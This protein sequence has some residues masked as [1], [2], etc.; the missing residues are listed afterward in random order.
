M[1][2]TYRSFL[3]DKIS[4]NIEEYKK[5]RWKSIRQAL[6]VSYSQAN[7]RFPSRRTS[8]K[9]RSVKRSRTTSKPKTTS[10]KSKRN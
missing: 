2:E 7:K 4:K 6:A 1:R 10:K 8:K 9:S 5:G 3:R